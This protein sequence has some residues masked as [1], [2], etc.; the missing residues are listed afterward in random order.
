MKLYF[1]PD[2]RAVRVAWCLEEMGLDYEIESYRVGQRELR[3]APYKQ[4]HPNGRIPALDTGEQII[5]E[6]GA[7]IQWLLATHE[8]DFVPPVGSPEFAQYLQWF[9][10]AEGM[11]MPPINA[12]VVETILLPPERRND[13]NVKR[14]Q[15]LMNTMLQTLE[16]HMEGRD[17]LAG[18]FSGAEF[19]CGHAVRAASGLGGDFSDKPNLRA[20]LDRMAARPA[21]QRALA[22]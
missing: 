17:W 13:T 8:T 7:I 10:Y 2:S 9:H 16:T 19:M 6:S 5:F 3:E 18:A 15:K 1:A 12:Y 4:V 11:L 21:L 20:Y 14:A 22:L